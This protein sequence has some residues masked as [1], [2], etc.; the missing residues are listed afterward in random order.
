MRR[1]RTDA[2]SLGFGL[3][4]LLC[5]LLWVTLH[6]ARLNLPDL[7]WFVAGALILAGVLGA[8]GAM[9]GGRAGDRTPPV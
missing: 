5:P 2:V 4:F 3:F 8:A 9:R 6:D 1:H 7:G